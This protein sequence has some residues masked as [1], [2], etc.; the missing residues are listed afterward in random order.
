[1]LLSVDQFL[2][3]ET[4]AQLSMPDA[5]HELF[6]MYQRADQINPWQM[7]ETQRRVM[8]H[9]TAPRLNSLSNS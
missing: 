2:L 8:Q 6:P 3:K 7:V 5:A 1:M 9:G 4:A